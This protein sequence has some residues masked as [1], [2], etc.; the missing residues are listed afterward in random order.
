MVNFKY[1][2]A[3]GLDIPAMTGVRQKY[4]I[5]TNINNTLQF[6]R[7]E[8]CFPPLRNMVLGE[9]AETRLQLPRHAEERFRNQSEKFVSPAIIWASWAGGK[10]TAAS[11]FCC[12]FFFFL[13]PDLFRERGLMGTNVLSFFSFSWSVLKI[14]FL[15]KA[16]RNLLHRRPAVFFYP[17]IKWWMNRP[18]HAVASP[19]PAGQILPCDGDT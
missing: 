8:Y 15:K 3:H 5:V 13:I 2:L 11:G 4:T 10:E 1:P 18:L 6:Y 19:P 14:E 9:R 16:L 12:F 17:E 7:R